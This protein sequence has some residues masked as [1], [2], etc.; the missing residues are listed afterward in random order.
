[1]TYTLIYIQS[2]LG[3]LL[4]IVFAS[5]A[6][7]FAATF[8]PI[9]IR[10]ASLTYVRISAF[11]TVFSTISTAVAA[12]TRALD[13]PDIPFGISL[14]ST[15]LNIILDLIFISRV[16]VKGINP[17]VNT[18]AA[19]KLACDGSGAIAGLLFFLYTSKKAIRGSEVELKAVTKPNWIAA[20]QLARAGIFTFIESAVRNA[21]YLW[22]ISGIV[23]MGNNYATAWGVFNTIRWGLIMVPV[24][25]LEASSSAFVGHKWGKWRRRIGSQV[26]RAKATWRDIYCMQ[27]LKKSLSQKTQNTDRYCH[28]ISLNPHWNLSPS[29]S[30]LR[31]CFSSFWR[32]LAASDP[33][34][35]IYPRM[36][37]SPVPQRWCGR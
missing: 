2:A 17:T 19:I 36:K 32:T 6:S 31:S 30:S 25:A 13:R 24:Q 16:R 18:Q 28:K 35:T 5:A 27:L 29:F 26:R 34:P 8:V 23:N 15:F 10:E 37:M 21:L 4:S 22:L 9:Q 11:S 7:S 20:K 1:M 3:L 12:A 33:L 14:V